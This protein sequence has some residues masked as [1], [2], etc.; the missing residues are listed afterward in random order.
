MSDFSR[1]AS[2]VALAGF[3]LAA[4]S[5]PSAADGRPT[6][7]GVAKGWSA[8]QTTTDDGRV[9]YALSKPKTTEPRKAA[10]D[11]IYLLISDWPSRQVQGELE[12]VPGYSY[13]DGEPVIAQVG[14]DKID[15]FTRNDGTSGSAWVKDPAD[16]AKLLEA[17]R[18]GST[19]AISGVSQRG[20]HTKDTYSLN[21]I[22]AMLDKVHD[23]CSK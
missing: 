1:M 18:H 11:P 12:V 15:F 6:L 3:G 5:A 23:A 16:E 8:Y 10:R 4:S 9:C 20:T 13:K 2:I 21:G 14:S 19:I 22:G 7:L 17:M